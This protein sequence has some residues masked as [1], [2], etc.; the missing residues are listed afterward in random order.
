MQV[1][2][3][4]LAN[5]NSNFGQFCLLNILSMKEW[6]FRFRKEW[7]GKYTSFILL[8]FFLVLC[9][10]IYFVYLALLKGLSLKYI[11]AGSFV[12]IFLMWTPIRPFI[13]IVIYSTLVYLCPMEGFGFSRIVTLATLFGW[14]VWIIKNKKYGFVKAKQNYLILGLWIMMLIS[15]I[16]AFNKSLCWES[17]E[18]ISKVFFFYFAAINLIDS[19]RYLNYFI[20]TILFIF[21]L[22]SIDRAICCFFKGMTY[23]GGP[24]GGDNNI[25]AI[26]LV[27]VIPFAFYFCFVEKSIIKKVILSLLF[28]SLIL[29]T[30]ATFSRGGFLGLVT[31]LGLIWLKTKYK[32]ISSF[33]SII[34]IIGVLFFLPQGYKDR[35]HSIL[36]YRQDGS[37]MGR[38]EAWK[39]GWEMIKDRPMTGVGL[40][41][42]SSLSHI[43]NPQVPEE[44]IEPH[45]SFIQIAAECGLIA[46]LFFVLLPVISI[47]ELWRLKRR[48][49]DTH[50]GKWVVS[51]A[52]MLEISFCGYLISGSF[53]H[54][55]HMLLFYLF[56][57][58]SGAI[59]QIAEKEE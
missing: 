4:Y 44:D 53:M 54:E 41:N 56:I 6:Y 34:L 9:L 24:G 17:L 40:G 21:G 58:L 48:F 59:K 14:L 25:F 55:A 2:L 3:N 5:S 46:L 11:F 18:N 32:L 27:M 51:M 43:Y 10:E 39:A 49:A 22:L 35:V 26:L 57:A 42:F 28:L 20:W 29:A 23:C 47:W 15:I 1:L 16:F 12:L 33:T 31:V 52:N 50:K 7:R 45:N 38:I 8:I 37:A 19:K 36:E 30:I 13:G